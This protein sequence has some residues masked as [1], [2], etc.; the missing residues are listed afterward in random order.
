MTRII[1]FI[2]FCLYSGYYAGLA[3][4]L[5][6]NFSELSRYYSI[7]FRVLLMILMLIVIH[8]NR[9]QI[10]TKQKSVLTF[11]FI[12]FWIIYILK[13]LYT[14]NLVLD[15]ELGRFWF[16][17]IF[18]GLTYVVLPYL[19]F[20]LVDNVKYRNAILNGLISSGF[21]LG[22]V[23]QVQLESSD[24]IARSQKSAEVFH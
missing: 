6:L 7:P 9:H 20:Y 12:V 15:G 1:Y 22:I 13:V 10:L 3:I 8:R 19:T 4:I 18:Y 24:T 17:Y 23:D 5:A 16:E 14:E 11:L 2:S 21:I